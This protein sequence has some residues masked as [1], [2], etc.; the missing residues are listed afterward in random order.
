ME[1]KTLNELTEEGYKEKALLNK[2]H[3]FYNT[4]DDRAI[5]AVKLLND[6]YEIQLNYNRYDYWGKRM[7]KYMKESEKSV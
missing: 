1:I 3:V 6:R 4:C 5:M 2:Y 7:E